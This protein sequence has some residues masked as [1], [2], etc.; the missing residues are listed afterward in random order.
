MEAEPHGPGEQ[1][2]HAPHVFIWGIAFLVFYAL[3]VGPAYKVIGG[4]TSKTLYFLYM[5][6]GFLY[7]NVPAVQRFYN[8]YMDDLW[9]LWPS[10]PAKPASAT[11]PNSGTST[12]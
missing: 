4:R 1:K 8:W 11:P 3:S 9:R 12:N 7:E 6:L 2:G 10:T 5:P